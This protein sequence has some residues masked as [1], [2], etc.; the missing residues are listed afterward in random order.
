MRTTSLLSFSDAVLAD[1][2]QGRFG[3]LDQMPGSGRL[4]DIVQGLQ[5]IALRERDEI[6]ERTPKVLRRVA[7]Y[8]IDIFDCQNPRAYTDDGMANLA[9]ILVVGRPEP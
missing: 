3:R 8:N 4:H 9:Q 7:G 2:S 5:R 1:G 6:I